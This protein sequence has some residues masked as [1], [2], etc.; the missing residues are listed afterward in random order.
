MTMKQHLLLPDYL[1]P[2]EEEANAYLAQGLVRDIEFSASTY[3]VQVV[4]AKTEEKV[5]AFL[6]L[7]NKG[8]IKDSFC[9]CEDGESLSHCV[10]IATAFL[11]IF[12]DQPLPLHLR[13]QN[14]LWAHLCQLYADRFGDDPDI[15]QKVSH[16]H[17]THCSYGGKEVFFVK[18]KTSAARS[19]L[20]DIMENRQKETEETSLKFSNLPQEE[21]I[22]WREGRPSAQLKYELSFWNDLAHW[23]I[24]MQDEGLSEKISFDY[25]SKGLPNL[26]RISFPALEIA[27]YLSEANLPKII[28]SLATVH[29]PIR[30]HRAS[31]DAIRRITYDKIAGTFHIETQAPSKESG[32]K[33]K[34]QLPGIE[35]DGWRFVPKDGFYEL[36]Q[37]QLLS[38]PELAGNQ[39][40][41][42]LNEHFELISSMLEG[43]VLHHDPIQLLYAIHFDAEW[44]LHIVAYAFTP[45][46]LNGPSS[47]Y[48]GDWVYL[49]DDGFYRVE[50][51]H[52]SEVET[53]IANQD[54][55]DFI[56]KERSWLNTQDG[57]HAYLVGVETQLSYTLSDDNRL[58]F[59][60]QVSVKDLTTQSKDFG[61][62]I[63]VAGKGFY[64]K[65]SN[66]I[67]LPLRPDLTIHAN[68]IPLFIRMNH[69]ELQ[70]VPGFFSERCPVIKV[71]LHVSLND[72]VVN[73]APEYELSPDYQDKEI[74][75]FDDVVYVHGEG[76]HDLPLDN[77]LPE[78]FRHALQLDSEALPLFLSYELETLMPYVSKIDSRLLKPLHTK[79]SATSIVKAESEGW[80]MLKVNY[81]TD[82]G[83]ISLATLRTALGKKKPFLFTTA[84][85]IDLKDPLFKWIKLLPKNRLDKRNNV[86]LLSTLELIRLN[87][88]EGLTVQDDADFSSKA[89]LEELTNFR[90]PSKPDLSGLKSALRSYQEHGLNWLWFLYHH[91][92]SGLLCDD[93]GLGKTHQAMALLAAIIN[94][95]KEQKSSEAGRAG[96]GCHFLIVCPTSVIYHWQDKLASY[97]PDLRVCTFY[98]SNRSLTE[99]HQQYDVLLTSYGVWRLENELLSTVPFEVAI[100]DEIQIAKNYNSRVHHSLLAVQA[101][102]RLG[103]TGTPIENHLRELKSLFDVVLPSYMPG[104]ADYKELFV[105]PIEKEN[106]KEKRELLKRF[107]KPFIL[108]RKKENVLPDLPEKSEEIAHCV[109]LPDQ[110]ALYLD[111]LSKTRQKILQ[112]LQ[113][114]SSPIPFVHIF[115][116]LSSLKQICNHPAAFLKIPEDYKKYASGKWDLFVELL[117]EAR[118]SQQKIVIFS[119]Y[120]AMLDIFEDYLNELGMG[121][122]TIRGSTTNRGEQIHRFNNDPECEVFLGSLH[123]AGLGVDLT[124]GSVV[125]HYDRWWNAAR[126]NQATDRVHRI[127]QTRGV[128]VFKLV[129]KGTFEERIDTLIAKKA[130]LMEDVVGIDDHRF[131][132]QFTR[133]ELIEL[134]QFVQ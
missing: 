110:K 123:A 105:K 4:D 42:V 82:R 129:T 125:I 117:D 59:S 93:M 87:A 75:F 111:V 16:G 90:T 71:G 38:T 127:G 40:S 28:P 74:R 106:S 126:E 21:L 7:D 103:L 53:V 51:T 102:M 80:Y 67:G 77:R 72:D 26:I 13:F 130:R 11:R 107:I 83:V 95:Y 109:L 43:T 50:E 91:N 94:F 35:L 79:L 5:W 86:L 23:L 68:Q 108:R 33:K 54:V 39:I 116:I 69:D 76:F 128:Q 89:L 133:E 52:F 24:A 104:D 118:E 112:Q 99:F 57:F 2:F 131:L 27:F 92:L 132:K 12:N 100:F 122:A 73:I 34:A 65:I 98:G 58:S 25:S 97:L 29:S 61:P 20:Q 15:L 115:S 41:Q 60:R 55:P 121:F 88:L 101:R 46:D 63:Y 134:L 56:R 14:S 66:P 37:H 85:L 44:N 120:L 113:E 19:K 36:D 17:Y 6:Q 64:S 124:A 96:I 31:L 70:L 81:Q 1:K 9:S 62:W 3:Q 47:R 22:L 119:Q 8:N 49:D 10:H 32:R 78:R 48:F 84:G 18:G 45:G 114:T 30:V